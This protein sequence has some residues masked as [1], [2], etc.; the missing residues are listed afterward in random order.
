MSPPLLGLVM[1]VRNESHGIAATLRSL[2]PYVDHFTIYDTGST[3]STLDAI[4]HET[5]AECERRG[6]GADELFGDINEC[7]FDDFSSARNR[8]L[9]W[10]DQRTVFTIMP[11]ADDVLVGGEALRT[12]L[13]SVRDAAD[14]AY[15]VAL[16]RGE[17]AYHLPLVLRTSARWRYSGRVHECCG[18]AGGFASV[19]IP[20]VTLTQTP[21]AQSL[22]ASRKRWERDLGMLEADLDDRPNDPRALFYLGQTLECLG[23]KEEAWEIYQQRVEV[24]GWQAETF[25]AAF[26]M[27]KLTLQLHGIA[28]AL[29]EFLAA[30]AIDPRRAEPLEAIAQHYYKTDNHALTYLF[31]RRA[32]EIP[33]PTTDVVFLDADVYDWKAADLVGISG[34]YVGQKEPSALELGRE[35]A[36]QAVEAR[37][38]DQR[39]RNN[40]SFYAKP[41][42]EAYRGVIHRPLTV[43]CDPDYHP[44]NPSICHLRDGRWICIVRT[45]NYTIQNIS[46]YVTP[47]GEPIN[48][49]NVMVTLDPKQNWAI[50]KAQPMEDLDPTPRTDFCVHGYEDCRLF[51]YDDKLY[52]TAT[53]CDFADGDQKGARE[54]VL[55]E[56][57]RTSYAITR[58]T[59]LRGPWSR[60]PQKNW[61]PVAGGN[62]IVY[63]TGSPTGMPPTSVMALDMIERKVCET[64]IPPILAMGQYRGGSQ[65]VT[66]R[67]LSGYV[68]L[69][70]EVSFDGVGN[71]TYLHRWVHYGRHD[72]H[73]GWRLNSMSEPFYFQNRGIEFAAGLGW[74]A[75]G[76]RFV[77]SYAVGDRSAWLGLFP[78]GG[79]IDSLR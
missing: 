70:H 47:N 67:G 23:R 14:P 52:A 42:A 8:V 7:P 55:L 66:C 57:D 53:V 34:F 39:L 69:V 21:P 2:L 77:V 29:P 26:R 54:I 16:R 5:A 61:M 37:P 31:A 4:E 46:D 27:A 11:D 33:K 25:E 74:D 58:A 15:L 51:E 63:A 71:R 35:A 19:K 30:H 76:G 9:E 22:E 20:G 18:G 10:H 1:I 60:M 59:P 75:E 73:V 40:L 50:T 36:E 72:R 3:D 12:F 24:G 44:L 38:A 78:V 43:A 45:V 13:E 62:A 79:V 64:T 41:S 6:V 48:T 49:R 28:E 17:L 32:M 65:L 56:I 68:G